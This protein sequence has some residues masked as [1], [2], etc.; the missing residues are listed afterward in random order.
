MSYPRRTGG[1]DGQG[2]EDSGAIQNNR[3]RS[4][5][6]GRSTA[7]LKIMIFDSLVGSSSQEPA[8]NVASISRA[9]ARTPRSGR[10]ASTRGTDT[11]DDSDSI[12]ERKLAWLRKSGFFSTDTNGCT[13]ERACSLSD[14]QGAYS[15]VHDVFVEAGYILPE[16][17]G[18][19]L[20]IYEACPETATF[21]A[22]K[23]GVI[24]G[25]LSVVVDS[26][27]FG[28]PSD[29]AFQP[30]LDALRRTGAK[31]CEVTNQALAKPYRRSALSTN[32]MSCAAA[33]ML[34]VGCH[35]AIATVSPSHSAFYEL[36]GFTLFG[37][38]RSYSDKVHDPVVAMSVDLAGCKDAPDASPD[39]KGYI[40]NIMT[41]RSNRFRSCA[42]E[43]NRR[44]R[45]RFLSA[46][47]LEGLFV[48]ERNF[49]W[50][51]SSLELEHLQRRWG[52][53]LFDEVWDA[54]VGRFDSRAEFAA[55]R[56]GPWARLKEHLQE[57]ELSWYPSP[58]VAAEET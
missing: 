13:I 31:L 9:S 58:E 32:L 25:V 43:W 22:K 56:R 28:L 45:A 48:N 38:E 29:H 33:Y 18:I 15:L 7:I 20:R 5:C 40:F 19:R 6:D 10:R 27:E 8:V 57:L 3:R 30:E 17:A 50:E 26:R 46:D 14:L 12:A 41:T 21:V 11:E 23:D 37:S 51:C 1:A 49:L 36:A 52:R 42:G 39:A 55:E 53:K 47:L 2:R 34:E 44:A 54:C 24:V 4:A 16:P 35:R